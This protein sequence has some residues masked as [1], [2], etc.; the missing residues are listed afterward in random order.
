MFLFFM[1]KIAAYDMDKTLIKTISGLEFPKDANDWQLLY[2]EIPGKI[3]KFYEDGYKI[4]ILS[5][6]AS[7]GTGKITL[8]DFKLKIERL[9]KKI[10]VPMQVYYLFYFILKFYDLFFKCKY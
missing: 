7:L 9:V 4:V 1:I 8:K 5:N 6:Q 10:G 3:K 2:A